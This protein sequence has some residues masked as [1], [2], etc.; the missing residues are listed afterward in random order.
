MK[1]DSKLTLVILIPF[2]SLFESCISHSCLNKKLSCFMLFFSTT[3]KKSNQMLV[4]YN[5]LPH[6]FSPKLQ[7]VFPRKFVFKLGNISSLSVILGFR[8]DKSA[9]DV[10]I[11]FSQRLGMGLNSDQDQVERKGNGSCSCLYLPAIMICQQLEN[12]FGI[13][14]QGL[15]S[16]NVSL[17]GTHT[18]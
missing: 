14:S 17:P 13:N 16:V 9:K 5:M 15:L 8:I 4:N 18:K 2:H 1:E 12:K 3:T 6:K 10:S 11:A 7:L